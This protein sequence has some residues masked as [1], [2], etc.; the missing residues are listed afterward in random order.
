MENELRILV[1]LGL[2]LLLVMLRVESDRF[3]VA[4]YNEPVRDRRASLRRRAD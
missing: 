3:G 1:G 2:T 4:V